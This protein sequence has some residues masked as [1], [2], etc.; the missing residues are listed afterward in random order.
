MAQKTV[1]C[2]ILKD[3]EYFG[4]EKTGDEVEVPER[5]VDALVAVGQVARVGTKASAKRD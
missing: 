4:A 1:K 3:P 2:K 5:L